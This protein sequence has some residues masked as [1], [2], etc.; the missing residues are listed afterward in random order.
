MKRDRLDSLYQHA[1][2]LGLDVEWA[3]LGEYR[4]GDYQ[5]SKSLIRLNHR[6]TVVQATA[7]LAHEIGHAIFGH[8]CSSPANERK[9]WEMGASLVITPAEYARA[10]A[11]VGP[12]VGALAVELEVT[13]RLIEAWRR[14]YTKRWP[15]ERGLAT[16]KA[17][18]EDV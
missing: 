11:I 2:D 15:V 18:T 3:D 16:P 5:R 14:W 12:H 1:V 8:T 7:T 13:P 4:R 6:L 17:V 10:E 9:A